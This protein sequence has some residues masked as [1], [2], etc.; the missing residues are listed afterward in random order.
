VEANR[1]GPTLPLKRDWYSCSDCGTNFD[2][3]KGTAVKRCLPC[4]ERHNIDRPDRKIKRR[5]IT[6]ADC[7]EVFQPDPRGKLPTRCPACRRNLELAQ[8]SAY[9]KGRRAT[10]V[11]EKTPRLRGPDTSATCRECGKILQIAQKGPLPTLCEECRRELNRKR[12]AEEYRKLKQAGDRPWI[13]FKSCLDC[14]KEIAPTKPGKRRNQRCDECRSKHQKPY[15]LDLTKS[16]DKHLRRFYR[17]TENDFQ[18]MN[19]EQNGGCAICGE[20]PDRLHVDHD[21][22]AGRVRG[23][24]C[25][26]CNR[27]IGIAKEDPARLA[28]AI[29]YLK[30]HQ[31]PIPE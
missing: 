12:R 3:G 26:S 5:P 20:K 2:P 17:M 23:L 24:L 15:L 18:R 16:R 1:I 31:T 11:E 9:A 7:G 13:R 14:G 29:K 4:R 6:C 30:E 22:N 19:Q 10:R 28:A 8:G 25:G 21:H 27:M